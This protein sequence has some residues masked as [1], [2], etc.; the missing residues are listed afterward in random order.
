M[1]ERRGAP[2]HGASF[3][4]HEVAGAHSTPWDAP[5]VPPFPFA[6]R[7]VDILTVFWRTDPAAIAR[8]V[9]PPLEPLGD[10][11][12]AHIYRMGDVEFAGSINECNVMVGARFGSGD[13]AVEG[14]YSVWQ[15]LDSDVGVAHGREVHG[16]PKKHADVGLEARGDLFVGHV[17]RNGIAVLTA[18]TPY[19]QRRC[20]PEAMLGHFDFRENIAFKS[21]PSIDGTPAIRQLTARRLAE[22]EIRECYAGPCTV[23]LRPNAQAPLWR[24]PV[25]EPLEGFFWRA[26]FTLVAGR[27]LHD[28]LAP[29]GAPAP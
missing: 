18:T 12:A 14:G 6:F 4:E 8:L 29:G 26:D 11:A 16:Q 25:L 28:Y 19:K 1:S 15:F 21:I 7:D 5:L 22:L 23:E 20:E 2:G 17:E 3:D 10:V 27:V 13:E 24:L 9:P